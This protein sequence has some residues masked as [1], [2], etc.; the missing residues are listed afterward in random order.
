MK[1]SRLLSVLIALLLTLCLTACQQPSAESSPSSMPF[2]E[3]SSALAEK[4]DFN[5]AANAL[6]RVCHDQPEAL[7][8]TMSAFPRHLQAA[9]IETTDPIELDNLMDGENGEE[10][11]QALLEQLKLLLESD[12][13]QLAFSDWDGPVQMLGMRVRDGDQ[14]ITPPNVELFWYDVD[15]SEDDCVFAVS[16]GS[17][18]ADKEF[19]YFYLTGG[20]QRF[21]PKLGT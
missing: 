20:F 7:A 4:D 16:V 8:S 2:G 1:L 14:P 3:D 18:P 9:G 21:V 13:A 12:D 10:V 6:Y 19:G 17:D 5:A 15:L 11:Q